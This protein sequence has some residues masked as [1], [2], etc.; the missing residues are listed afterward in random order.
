MKLY[1][2]PRCLDYHSPGH[3]ERPDRVRT[4]VE[5]I[6]ERHPEWEWPRVEPA[7]IEDILRAHTQLHLER[8][9]EPKD[10]D[11]DT[12]YHEDI[13]EIA[14]LASGSSIG[15]MR[16]A[17][18]GDV[19]FSLMRPPGHHAE[20]NRAMGFCYLNHVAIA[21]LAAL[22]SGP[23][24]VAIWDFDAH[25]GNGTE[26]IVSGMDRIRY[27][28]VHQ[29][30]CYPGTGIVSH[31]NAFNFPVS[32]RTEAAEHMKILS[33]SWE[34][35]LDFDPDLILV[36]AGFDAYLQDP[37][38]QMRLGIDDFKTLGQWLRRTSCPLAATLEGGYSEDL[39]LLVDAFL[40]GWS[41]D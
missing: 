36:S 7:S 3:P 26:A 10:F 20:S 25:H 9:Q 22:D 40:E 13:F 30:P 23:V 33:K 39:P 18:K 32:P 28:S 1:T 29:H 37:L 31:D 14:R 5:L 8:L 2:D 41:E 34:T 24:R 27:V 16:S 12:A 35:V 4:T 38:T 19:A 21:A 15:A 11:G 17:L 6:Q